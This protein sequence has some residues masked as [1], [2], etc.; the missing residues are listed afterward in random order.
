MASLNLQ[1]Y[2]FRDY[3]KM[4]NKVFSKKYYS[5]SCLPDRYMEEFWREIAFGKMDYVEYASDVDGSAFSS[6][7]HDQLGKSNWNLKVNLSLSL[8]LWS[9]VVCCIFH[10]VLINVFYAHRE[11]FTAPQFCFATSSDTNWALSQ[12]D[13]FQKNQVVSGHAL[14]FCQLVLVSIKSFN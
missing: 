9:V 5:T 2:T 1:K 3:K 13:L 10:M 4:A 8:S 11:F 6:S 12:I 14:V 7:S